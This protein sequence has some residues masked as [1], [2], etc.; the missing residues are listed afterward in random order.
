MKRL[1]FALSACGLLLPACAPSGEVTESADPALT[2]AD[3]AVAAFY[4]G[5]AF[6][7]LQPKAQAAVKA[8]LDASKGQASRHAMLDLFKSPSWIL[9]G[10]ITDGA[11]CTSTGADAQ[12]RIALWL[13]SA[14]IA[15]ESA[16]VVD[17]RLVANVGTIR[18]ALAEGVQH[19]DGLFGRLHAALAT[20][21]PPFR[22][23]SFWCATTTTG[24]SPSPSPTPAP[25]T[26]T[27]PEP[28]TTHASRGVESAKDAQD[29]LAD[30][31]RQVE[32][33]PSAG[34]VR[35]W[36]ALRGRYHASLAKA[37]T[38]H[39]D[40]LRDARRLGSATLAR[41][42]AS[43]RRF[44]AAADLADAMARRGVA[45]DVGAMRV[46]HTVV[47]EDH[48]GRLRVRGEEVSAG[49]GK[50]RA[51]LPGAAVAEATDALFGE[52]RARLRD[53]EAA[54]AMAALVDQ[55]LI[56]IHPFMNAN[57]RTTR[58]VSNLV[59]A[60]AGF[61]PAVGVEDVRTTLFWQRGAVDRDAAL[62]RITLGM[63]HAVR[64]LEGGVA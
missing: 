18:G 44:D 14:G 11:S 1:L 53:G 6:S 9:L 30:L 57:G 28:T 24:A 60:R 15:S 54:P 26:T 63:N 43:A 59:L 31:F 41:D 21:T 20:A 4:A 40:A 27:K 7:T 35:D 62:E 25:G 36:D 51:Y 33:A 2:A 16:N 34:L 3:P 37:P 39:R 46:L 32:V 5:K 22:E 29:A 56:S 52:L 45:A 49:H 61:P 42:A 64:L 17:A 10:G 38:A 19:L 12:T 13:E 48:Q 23:P 50:D 58:L 8:A 55:R 47:A